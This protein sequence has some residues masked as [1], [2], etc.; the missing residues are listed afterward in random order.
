MA[1]ALRLCSGCLADVPSG[2]GA[3]RRALV[4]IREIVAQGEG[5][6][7]GAPPRPGDEPFGALDNYGLRDDGTIGP[8]VGGRWEASHYSKF[9]AIASGQVPLGEVWPMGPNPDTRSLRGPLRR[10]SALFD[11]V[12]GLLLRA[13]D[14]AVSEPSANGPFFSTVLPLMHTALPQL[15]GALMQTPLHDGADP[16]V[17]PNAGPAFLVGDAPLAEVIRDCDALVS[18]SAVSPDVRHREVW[19]P[20]LLATQAVLA[21]LPS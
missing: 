10:L 2:L 14:V 20:A 13:I 17:G 7:R 21:A 6:Q 9:D 18:S 15:A 12:Y 1:R 16:S 8:I 19:L 4:A 5:A 11:D 3:I